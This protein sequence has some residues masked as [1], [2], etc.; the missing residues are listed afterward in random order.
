MASA[1]SFVATAA[2]SLIACSSLET[3][4][5][6]KSK[7][8]QIILL[9]DDDDNI[10]DDESKKNDD[11]NEYKGDEREETDGI[12]NVDVNENGNVGTE[13]DNSNSNTRYVNYESEK[14]ETKS[15]NVTHNNNNRTTVEM[16]VIS[17]PK[18][19]M[20]QPQRTLKPESKPENRLFTAQNAILELRQSRKDMM[21]KQRR[22]GRKNT[23]TMRRQR[24][25]NCAINNL[26]TKMDDNRIKK[27]TCEDEKEDNDDDSVDDYDYTVPMLV[28]KILKESSFSCRGRNKHHSKNCG[29]KN[30]EGENR[31]KELVDEVN[32]ILR[33][34]ESFN[35]CGI[36]KDDDSPNNKSE[37]NDE[38]EELRYDRTTM[39]SIE[40]AVTVLDYALPFLLLLS[41][42]PS[43]KGTSSS[44]YSPNVNSTSKNRHNNH[45]RNKED[46]SNDVN[47]K[48]NNRDNRKEYNKCDEYDKQQKNH[49]E[50]SSS[51]PQTQ[52][53]GKRQH[54][55]S[56]TRLY[57][58]IQ[59]EWKGEPTKQRVQM[60]NEWKEKVQKRKRINDSGADDRY[61]N[62]SKRSNG[63]EREG[64]DKLSL[65]KEQ[66]KERQKLAE[67]VE[68]WCVG[69]ISEL[70]LPSVDATN[71]EYVNTND[72]T[73]KRIEKRHDVHDYVREHGDP[74]NN[75]FRIPSLDALLAQT[76]CLPSSNFMANMNE[77]PLQF[78][79]D[80]QSFLTSAVKEPGVPRQRGMCMTNECESLSDGGVFNLGLDKHN[81]IKEVTSNA[82]HDYTIDSQ[83]NVHQRMI[84]TVFE[85]ENVMVST[86]L[87]LL[88]IREVDNG[89][90][91]NMKM[92]PIA[93]NWASLFWKGEKTRNRLKKINDLSPSHKNDEGIKDNVVTNLRGCYDSLVPIYS[94]LNQA[95]TLLQSSSQSFNSLFSTFSEFLHF[96]HQ[97]SHYIKIINRKE[98]VTQSEI[99][100]KDLV[101]S[102]KKSIEKENYCTGGRRRLGLLEELAFSNSSFTTST[103]ILVSDT[104]TPKINY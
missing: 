78:E 79:R 72:C 69:V 92:L 33:G 2:Q 60:Q 16:N 44:L 96:H 20:K 70:M 61:Q 67:S 4:T 57:D 101:N 66:L 65:R 49:K 30:R 97:H 1:S 47:K 37:D 8:K 89:M 87:A 5:T 50:I 45:N 103:S 84:Q 90:V 27:G 83:S 9:S 46:N 36:K 41:S 56:Q 88:D 95:P 74:D 75:N 10:I 54:R 71:L 91:I 85:V 77:T 11:S 3:G 6:R 58:D 28:G 73:C 104:H 100:E 18:Q 31:G 80:F 63:K 64:E 15:K 19:Q 14:M 59:D 26:E 82:C 39:L 17:T 99:R 43:T 13:F 76:S 25:H 55:H 7:R 51:I 40:L 22:Q 21:A 52:N 86:S 42:S 93:R 32:Q 38:G 34:R 102:T 68:R 23:T 12:Q 81:R 53:L 98:R 48:N 35:E 24:P 29:I 62:I 94:P